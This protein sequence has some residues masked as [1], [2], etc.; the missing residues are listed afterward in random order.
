MLQLIPVFVQIRKG[1]CNYIHRR[2]PMRYSTAV[3]HTNSRPARIANL[4]NMT[5]GQSLLIGAGCTNT[6]RHFR[7]HPKRTNEAPTP[8]DGHDSK[9]PP[10]A[11]NCEIRHRRASACI[12]HLGQKRKS[13][14]HNH[15]GN[16][17]SDRRGIEC[18]TL[19]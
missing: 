8:P 14:L 7:I 5:A 11:V 13:N 16:G 3:Y 18:G 4:I 10:T 2:N 12:C 19:V 1:P 17:L 6:F 15:A 9:K